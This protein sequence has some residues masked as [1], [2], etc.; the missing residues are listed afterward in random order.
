MASPPLISMPAWVQLIQ[1]HRGLLVPASFMLLLGVILV[2]LPPLV[3]DVLLASNITISVI[4]LMTTMYVKE[5]L[6][7]SV[8]PSLLL[9]T[10]LLRLVLNVA[11]TRLVLNANATSAEQAK[12]M[13]GKVIAAFA[14]FVAGGNLVVGVVIF[15]ILVVVQ[16]V[17]ITKGA[18]RISEVA[19]R[20]TLDAMPGKQMAI[21][22]DLNAGVIDE[23]EARRRRERIA[24][25][26][27]FFGAM[28]GA[29]KFVRGDAVAGIVITLV[30]IFGGFAVG[31]L[32]KGWDVAA[33][34]K[35]FTLLTIGDGL[36]AQ[37]PAFIIAIA[38][39]LVV[40]RAGSKESLGDQLTGQL[41]GRPIALYIAA[42]FCALL[43]LTPLPTIP[44]F[45]L[46][47]MLTA[48]GYFTTRQ[49]KFVEQG[50]RVKAEAEAKAS[51]PA[52]KVEDLLKVDVLELE[53][54]FGLVSLV[55]TNQGGD[56][57]ERISAI[58]RQLAADIGLVMPPVRIRDNQLLQHT[59]YRV[60]I[61]GTIVAE[62]E[63]RPGMLLA[64]DSGITTG[65]IQ[66]EHTK[67][68]AYGLDAWWIVPALKQRAETMNYTVVDPSSVLAT[69]LTEIVR[70]HADELLTREEVSNLVTQLKQTAPKLVEDAIPG[71][72]K[73]GELQKV[74][75]ALLRERV[76]IRDLETIV[77]TLSDWGAKTKDVEVLTEYVRNALR[78]SICAQ[79]TTIIDA[80]AFNP[81]RSNLRP[82]RRARLVCVTLD[83]AFEDLISGHIDRSPAGTTLT[84]PANVAALVARRITACLEPV[85]KGGH[86]PVLIASPQVRAQV[87]QILEPFMPNAVVLGY[88]EIVSGIEV[89]SM[90]LVTLPEG[91]TA[92]AAA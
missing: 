67:E 80:P 51:I 91:A 56:L 39:A 69:H 83:P 13:A 14:G 33:T 12:E 77:E 36:A 16:F 82:V 60:K 87:R 20:F 75:Q 63:T 50:A 9:G 41:T 79:Y 61:R 48:I 49:G 5:P 92:T 47:A 19:A 57:L 62:G 34:A 17:V 11:T 22:A 58:R 35:V 81:D 72:V 43:G 28:D 90:G 40:T 26:A 24:Q 38:S 4:V 73:P 88:N 66:G 64:M 52:P 85:L 7:F 27:D 2:P 18:T 70:A 53:V 55:D 59:R 29:S 32:Q 10:T 84:M 65:V 30:N 46:A 23:K 45:G 54:G 15:I 74:L 78:R 25:E 8:F 31:V 6:D 42:G 68:P 3:L 76:P 21:D 1:K 89:E 44:L 86:P 37:I 71:V